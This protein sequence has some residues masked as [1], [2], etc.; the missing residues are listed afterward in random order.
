MMTIFFDRNKHICID[1]EKMVTLFFF[2]LSLI[3]RMLL[4]ASIFG[5]FLYF[6]RK[7]GYSV[8]S[9]K[10]LLFLTIRSVISTGFGVSINSINLFKWAVMIGLSGICIVG[11]YKDSDIRSRNCSL[12]L[13]VFGI[14]LMCESFLYSSFPVVSAFKIFSWAFVFLSV[15][16]VVNA[17][18][19]ILWIDEV[20]WYLNTLIL[21]SPVSL[22]LGIGYMRNGVA[23]QGITNQPNMYG[24]LTGIAFSLNLY[25]NT[26]RKAYKHIAMMFI[27]AVTCFFSQSRTGMAT[28]V[29]SLL[30]LLL[31]SDIQIW[32]KLFLSSIFC[33]LVGFVLCFDFEAFDLG[34]LIYR[35]VYK[36]NHTSIFY[37]RSGTIQVELS[38][39]RN[40]YFF[41]S[42][43]MVPFS[44]F[45][46]SYSF[47][48]DLVVEPG[49][50]IF[51]LLGDV[52]II[53]FVLFCIVFLYFFHL[54]S[55]EKRLLFFIPF[56]VSMG[57]MMFFSSNSI[58]ILYYIFFAE[59]MNNQKKEV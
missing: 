9:V 44:P 5:I 4:M 53:G 2:A 6:V 26:Q 57:E 1:S 16:L 29:F 25:L 33:L 30:W 43:F 23:F 41:G 14:F 47:S 12:I 42:G 28:I 24:V 56:V 13:I 37:S 48:F 55:K 31:F 40:N 52:G 22:F 50:L 19:N 20:C 45:Y 38:K 11:L 10:T 34:E 3:N 49:N 59:C 58:A 51:A 46:K 18:N 17:S 39:F 8:A 32:K 27:C 7:K 54:T 36:G 35:F 15:I 21:L